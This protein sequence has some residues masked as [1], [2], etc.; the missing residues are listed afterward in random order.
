ME[1]N[2]IAM[3]LDQTEEILRLKNYS[4]S[5]RKAYLNC[6]R[7]FL[8]GCTNHQPPD[9]AMIKSFI[10]K[11]QSAGASSSTTNVYLQAI[12]FY[13]S[14]VLRSPIRINIPLAKRSK[15]LPVTLTKNE[16]L[17]ILDAIANTKHKTMIALAYGSGLRVSE[18]V[19]LRVAN[20][21]L[22]SKTVTVRAG[23]GQKD[24]ISVLPESLISDLR[25]LKTGKRSNDFIFS[26]ER[27]GKLTSRTAQKVFKN[28]L[29][30]SDVLK[31]AT[32]HSLRHSFATHVLENGTD[33]RY[34]QALLGHNN[35]RTT[36]Q[37]THVTNPALKNILSPL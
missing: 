19:A 30:T 4:P 37:Y 24:R 7:S 29:N 16:I 23:K 6:L 34:V 12:K 11:K 17:R 32:F 9:E 22:E 5:T 35:I 36:Q 31:P 15:R 28:A 25:V 33:V 1:E 18:V 10:L 13:F 14:Q 26:S 20:I 3:A 21:D 8:E 2:A 27:G